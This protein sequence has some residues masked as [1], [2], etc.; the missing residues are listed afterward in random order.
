MMGVLDS[1]YTVRYN[2]GMEKNTEKPTKVTMMWPP[3]VIAAMRRLAEAHNR[4]L[5][6]EVVWALREYIER[7]VERTSKQAS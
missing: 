6:G 2:H 5:T 7:H 3:S 4:S 1:T